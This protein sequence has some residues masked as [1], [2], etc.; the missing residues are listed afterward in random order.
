MDSGWAAALSA[1]VTTLVVAITALAA[2]RQLVQFR[3]ANDIVVYLRLVDQLDSPEMVKARGRL[4]EVAVKLA[5]DPE[6][7]ERLRDPSFIP[8]DFRDVGILLRTLEHISVLIIKGGVAEDLVLAEYADN[9]VSMWEQLHPAIIERRH[10]FGPHTARAF[11]HLAM[12]S[13]RY[14]ESGKMDRDYNRLARD[15]RTH[16]A[17]SRR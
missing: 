11:E 9:F 10:A 13:K 1:I 8:D 3:N 14:I 5:D 6:Y 16:S 17:S 15:P 2:F 7:R 12:R 4:P